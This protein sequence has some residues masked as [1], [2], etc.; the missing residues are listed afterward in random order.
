MAGLHGRFSTAAAALILCP[1]AL[2]AQ[3][4]NGGATP[5]EAIR[6]QEIVVTA[7]G[8]EQT[9]LSAPASIT[10]LA[11]AE[12]N[13][14]RAASLAEVLLSVEGIDVGGTAG[15]TGGLNVSMRGMPSEYTLVLIDGRRQNS[16]GNVTPNGFGE[17]SSGFLPPVSAIERIEI[18]RGPVATLYGSDAMG[19]VVNI[20]TKKVAT[21]WSGSFTTD[22]TLQQHESFGN[23]YSGSGTVR[24]PV[25][26]GLAS[27]TLRGSRLHREASELEPTGVHGGVEISRRGPSPVQA[28][29]YSFGGRFMVTPGSAHDIHARLGCRTA[30]LR[31]LAGAAGHAGRSGGD[32]GGGRR[33]W[34]G[35]ALQPRTGDA[36]AHVASGQCRALVECDAQYDGDGGPDDPE[37]HAGRD[38][39]K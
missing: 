37:R 7:T 16:A 38:A 21:Q 36:V 33:L 26:P 29:N 31:Q 39:G 17:T 15:K 10:V 18:I 8:F 34:S 30:A 22:A 14:R 2:M 35:A 20:I 27:L 3:G 28:D 5:A 32:A 11:P 9:R 6:L 13:S 1:A 25:V 23:V 12:L 4:T 19:G 24:G